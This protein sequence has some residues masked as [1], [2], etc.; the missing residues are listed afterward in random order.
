MTISLKLKIKDLNFI[1]NTIGI[2][3]L[4]IFIIYKPNLLVL[5]LISFLS[6]FA[7]YLSFF[8][9]QERTAL[10]SILISVMLNTFTIV[11][12]QLLKVFNVKLYSTLIFL[13]FIILPLIIIALN[14]RKITNFFTKDNLKKNPDIFF[15]SLILILT[16]IFF[17]VYL[18]GNYLPKEDGPT[19][20]YYGIKI[21]KELSEE[22]TIYHWNEDFFTGIPQLPLESV[23]GYY[24][25]GLTSFLNLFNNDYY[26]DI[27]N[28]QIVF[29]I[30]L[31]LGAYLCFRTAN[32]NP[33]LSFFGILLLFITDFATSATSAN[34]RKIFPV[35]LMPLLLFFMIN[36]LKGKNDIVPLFLTGIAIFF[37][38]IVYGIGSIIFGVLFIIAFLS[39]DIKNIIKKDFNKNYLF[40]F[41]KLFIFGA[42]LFGIA[43]FYIYNLYYYFPGEIPRGID[44]SQHFENTSLIKNIFNSIINILGI[45]LRINLSFQFFSYFMIFVIVFLFFRLSKKDKLKFIILKTLLLAMGIYLLVFYLGLS[46][47]PTLSLIDYARMIFFIIPIIVLYFL[48]FLEYIKSPYKYFVIFFF[49]IFIF[50]LMFTSVIEEFHKAIL[51]PLGT[52]HK[53]QIPLEFR[54]YM[55][56]KDNNRF[57]LYCMNYFA[58]GPEILQR[59]DL[60]T[61]EGNVWEMQ[62]LLSW[63]LKNMMPK[64]SNRILPRLDHS[65]VYWKNFM[66]ITNTKYAL[67]NFCSCPVNLYP[68]FANNFTTIN[69]DSQCLKIFEVDTGGFAEKVTLSYP[70]KPIND[71]LSY[72]IDNINDNPFY[73]F[74]KGYKHVFPKKINEHILSGKEIVYIKNEE[75]LNLLPEPEILKTQKINDEHYIIFGNFKDKDFVYVKVNYFPMWEAFMDGKKLNTYESNTDLTLIETAKGNNI[76]FIYRQSIIQKALYLTFLICFIL[77]LA[78]SKKFIEM[79]II[80]N[81]F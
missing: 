14:Y 61:S 47:S 28:L 27:A 50:Y 15:I 48:F 53:N 9:N 51:H 41:L 79:P 78:Y 31:L 11:F 25:M 77:V 49:C 39:L 66:R 17:S 52:D 72:N 64:Q 30:I 67:I 80:K 69:F 60:D 55:P 35:S 70:S 65:P 4:V 26:K 29:T 71:G 57:A 12:T 19:E 13:I 2:I 42:L 62:S 74:P 18:T 7:L 46:I 5:F 32:I 54:S 34:I 76:E 44:Y 3:L 10:E 68:F 33:T 43:L 6:G 22:K 1:L 37:H 56:D 24:R 45:T 36:I 8:Y 16:L 73:D 59:T 58:K 40:F 21:E 20:S 23:A 75:E 63:R 38:H 81:E